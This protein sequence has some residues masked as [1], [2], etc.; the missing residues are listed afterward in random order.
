MG[1]SKLFAGKR[2]LRTNDTTEYI[3]PGGRKAT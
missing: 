2:I 1:L 3:Y